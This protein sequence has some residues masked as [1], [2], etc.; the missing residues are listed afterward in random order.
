[1][2]PILGRIIVDMLEHASPLRADTE[3]KSRV[4][5]AP[6]R[7][8]ECRRPRSYGKCLLKAR[9]PAEGR[10]HHLGAFWRACSP[11]R[12]GN[13]ML[14]WAGRSFALVLLAFIAP[15]ELSWRCEGS[16]RH[17]WPPP[18]KYPLPADA[19]SPASGFLAEAVKASLEGRDQQ[20]M[21]ALQAAARLLPR[22][23]S[24]GAMLAHTQC[25]Q[26][27]REAAMATM[28][29][30]VQLK[31]EG[32]EM[33][34]GVSGEDEPWKTWGSSSWGGGAGCSPLPL[35]YPPFS[36]VHE[37]AAW[38]GD[39]DVLVHKRVYVVEDQ[40]GEGTLIVTQS[41]DEGPLREAFVLEE[42]G[43]SLSPLDNS[44]IPAPFPAVL[45][46][47]APNGSNW[48]AAAMTNFEAP[49]LTE[50]LSEDAGYMSE[51]NQ[52][53][54]FVDRLL[55]MLQQLQVAGITHRAI[56]PDNILVLAGDLPAL[57]GFELAVAQGMHFEI[58]R[59]PTHVAEIY[60]G[61]DGD[62]DLGIL[63]AS[64]VYALGAMVMNRMAGAMPIFVP[65][66][67]MM[68]SVRRY[69]R[70]THVL[71]LRLLMGACV[72][73]RADLVDFRRKILQGRETFR[74]TT[75]AF[76]DSG[77]AHNNLGGV[78]FENQMY[79]DA[80]SLFL[81]SLK[82]QLPFRSGARCNVAAVRQ[83][84][85]SWSHRDEDA[86]AVVQIIDA[87]G[88]EV[89]SV[90][91]LYAIALNLTMQQHLSISRAGAKF[92]FSKA[93]EEWVELS[94][95]ISLLSDG[96]LALA[97]LSSD[98]LTSHAVAG[99]MRIVM[100]LHDTA[101]INLSLFATKPDQI[102]AA[103]DN[104]QE[105]GLGKATL[106][107]ASAM[108][109]SQLAS[110]INRLGVHIVIDC[111]GQTGRD[112]MIAL[113]MRPAAI[114]VHFLGF[115]STLGATFIDH[116]IGDRHVS[117]P[118]LAGFYTEKLLVLP[119]TFQ[120]T[121]HRHR[122]PHP[123]NDARSPD[124]MRGIEHVGN[125]EGEWE[126]RRYHGLNGR[127]PLLCNFNQHFKLD[128]DMFAA[129]SRI[130]SR[131]AGSSLVLLK[132]PEESEPHIRQAAREVGLTG[133]RL[134][135]L[136]KAPLPEHLARTSFC[137]IF[138]DNREYNSGTTCTDALWA[139]SPTISLP[140]EKHAGR[141]A[142]SMLSTLGA[143]AGA[144]QA[145]DLHDYENM[146]VSLLLNA[147]KW[148]GVYSALVASREDS[149]L[150]DPRVWVKHVER[151]VAG[152][153]EWHVAKATA[154][155]GTV[156]GNGCAGAWR[157]QAAGGLEKCHS[158]FAHIVVHQ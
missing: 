83:M 81:E 30:A 151:A 136:P 38:G 135:L 17:E 144:L 93:R 51:A 107:D 32:A 86:Q 20:A 28:A 98:I 90:R 91:N 67:E 24:T 18:A 121:G 64:D 68:T 128:P 15:L 80:L 48:Q 5:H 154:A 129:W 108:S 149:P 29:R 70:V 147:T 53:F 110:S 134:I 156:S 89:R 140:R 43:F 141:H 12:E 77:I 132:Y 95:S 137:D 85:C 4:C 22:S 50:L 7:C 145:R 112:A 78:Y 71:S 52:V 142:A 114:Q 150:W 73:D 101:R 105:A 13:V 33:E 118:D 139:G 88:D 35:L 116:I 72:E 31:L 120:V 92:S 65:V 127:G 125:G 21:R 40:S 155:H 42:L 153:Y 66:L 47:A 23:P 111:N 8:L 44:G 61:V 152:A 157:K 63:S 57:V 1:M 119:H 126:T 16:Q 27:M 103:R 11:G 102:V 115:P 60:G 76:P 25:Q 75:A 138:V 46:S 14:P 158:H 117:P 143:R 122:M 2:S 109:Q 62:D 59:L 56:T 133:K 104:A 94:P 148:R 79:N 124:A 97:Y 41:T 131:V 99:S 69:E 146:A 100:S 54:D 36:V 96:R 37:E 26:G 113:S 82:L 34:Y 74:A 45:A 130:V 106:V 55:V 84:T 9:V 39:G 10:L 49:T 58:P 19:G 3:P 6:P 87:G 123:W